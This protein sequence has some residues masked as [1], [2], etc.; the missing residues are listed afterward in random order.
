MSSNKHTASTRQARGQQCGSELQ[1][2]PGACSI[3]QLGHENLC[4]AIMVP[5]HCSTPHPLWRGRGHERRRPAGKKVARHPSMI[6]YIA[7]CR[8]RLGTP[9]AVTLL[10][11]THM[12]CVHTHTRSPR[13][14]AVAVQLRQR[15]FADAAATSI[16][17]DAGGCRMPRGASGGVPRR[18][19]AAAAS[20][21]ARRRCSP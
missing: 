5:Q 16:D 8:R 12:R 14:R 15:A 18:H 11:G 13:P 3:R 1:G 20:A 6:P 17:W 4:T 21:C 9:S 7:S 2:L 10:L 19:A